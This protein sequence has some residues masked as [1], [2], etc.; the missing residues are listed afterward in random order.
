MRC[1]LAALCHV[2]VLPL[3]ACLSACNY[4]T[5]AQQAQIQQTLSVACTVDGVVV[6]LAQPVVATMG[7]AGASVAS[8]D[9]LLVHPAVVAACAAINGVPAGVTAVSPQVAVPPTPASH[10]V[11]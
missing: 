2:Y 5:P 9:A 8:A 6:P 7:P 10:P 11:G 4:A 3:L 1:N